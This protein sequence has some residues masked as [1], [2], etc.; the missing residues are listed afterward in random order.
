MKAEKTIAL[1]S[2]SELKHKSRLELIELEK[3]PI[4]ANL[5]N[6]FILLKSCSFVFNHGINAN[7]TLVHLFIQSFSVIHKTNTA[8]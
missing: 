7:D 2:S 6:I 3:K 1:S 4:S 5:A 8:H